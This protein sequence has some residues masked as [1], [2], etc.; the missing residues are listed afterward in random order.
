MRDEEHLSRERARLEERRAWE[1]AKGGE[2]L[3]LGLKRIAPR[4]WTREEDDLLRQAVSSLGPRQWRRVAEMV[5]GRSHVQCLQRWKKVLCPGL[6]KGQWTAEEDEALRRSVAKGMANWGAVAR[7]V[8]GRTAK[9]CRE[10][11]GNYL[12]PNVVQGG[13]T[14]AEDLLLLERHRDLGRK[15]A[16]IARAI[17]GRSENS[18]KLRFKSL[19]RHGLVAA[20]GE[21]RLSEDMLG[22]AIAGGGGGGGGGGSGGGSGSGTPSQASAGDLDGARDAPAGDVA[23]TA[24]SRSETAAGVGAGGAGGGSGRGAAAPVAV[25]RRATRGAG[26]DS[27][28]ALG[29]AKASAEAARP[30][31][32]VPAG[33][34]S[35]V[36]RA[37]HRRSSPQ[38]P[39]R[40]NGSPQPATIV[41]P[42]SEG[43]PAWS[44]SPHP[45]GRPDDAPPSKRPRSDARPQAPDQLMAS[46]PM[47]SSH[48]AGPQPMLSALQHPQS[49]LRLVAGRAS[50]GARGGAPGE[51]H[52]FGAAG[53]PS[54]S[55]LL[56]AYS[57][58]QGG[59][60]YSMVPQ[61]H[62]MPPH[63]QGDDLGGGMNG[64]FAHAAERPAPPPPARPGVLSLPPD[65][66][67]MGPSP[68]PHGGVSMPMFYTGFH[69]GGYPP[70]ADGGDGHGHS[71]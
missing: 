2:P 68:L 55:Q 38:C 61:H 17:K 50:A 43:H 6:R 7:D 36:R 18:V 48:M 27:E 4:R 12:A 19:E 34:G 8:P 59:Y 40:A 26:R 62:M 13:W 15:W 56:P 51:A 41:V 29:S 24:D 23:E 11:W 44:S 69:R 28:R 64:G 57:M 42:G 46:A 30:T 37:S 54:H 5:P 71:R 10:R 39:A 9:Q 47:A 21:G 14:G 1:A 67:T 58:S 33:T 66:V 70:H 16:T 63:L 32:A 31:P 22:D 25:S 3:P 65:L 35:D 20:F 49:A 53:C 52:R 60:A 45:Y